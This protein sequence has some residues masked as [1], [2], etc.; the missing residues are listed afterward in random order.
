MKDISVRS[1][2]K[3]LKEILLHRPGRELLNLTPDTFKNL[4]FD[5]IPYL[6]KARQ[7]HDEFAKKLS[8]NGVEI[9]YLEDLMT[10]TLEINE[11]IKKK[12]IKQFIKEA[13]VKNAED[14]KK[15]FEY[16][17]NIQSTKELVLQTMEGI[18]LNNSEKLITNPMPNLYFTKDPFS[19]IY[20]GIILNNMLSVT[21]SREVIY[22]EYIVNYHPRF[23]KLNKYYDRHE[24]YHIE[25]GDILILDDHIIGIGISERTE[26]SAI[27]KLAENIFKISDEK[28]DT[29][30]AFDIPKSRSF[31]HLDT[32]LT[33][34][35]IDKFV[36]YK[37]ID[38]TLKTFVITSIDKSLKIQ[39]KQGSM[40]EILSKYL[41]KNI[42]IIPC[43]GG[44]KI[45]SAREQ[46]NDGNNTLCIAP[47]KVI[48]YDRNP[49]TNKLLR[50]NGITV[51]E[52][53][54]SEL[55][56]GR[57]G[58]RCMSLPLRRDE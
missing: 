12:F 16:L 45:A 48:T 20:D 25:G 19:I 57:G 22:G 34:V 38:K 4:L 58:T 27:K 36:Y 33:Q 51:I 24:K 5:D 40:Q 44:D 31:I 55:S 2:I 15:L 13:E 53:S 8:E 32:V 7:E 1:E 30:L 18:K 46:W 42:T 56:R 52:I 37:E 49:E 6:E 21:R 11:K 28:V 14:K 29:I 26:I 35:D 39:Q 41:N 50:E 47:G 23:S 3:P 10:E 17:M 43:A 9:V 54:G